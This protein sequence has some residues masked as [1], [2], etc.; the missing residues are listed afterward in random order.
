V[1]STDP[2]RLDVLVAGPGYA[3]WRMAWNGSAWSPWEN[4]GGV[5]TSDPDAVSW[6][7]D[8]FDVFVRGPDGGLWHKWWISGSWYP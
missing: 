5:L 2:D 7:S 3:L 4:L 1:A 8:T 6:G